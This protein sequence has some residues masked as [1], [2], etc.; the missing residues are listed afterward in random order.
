[1]LTLGNLT[2]KFAKPTDFN[3]IEDLT[4]QSVFPEP[5]EAALNRIERGFT[6]VILKHLHESPTCSSPM[7]ENVARIQHAY[8]ANPEA[9]AVVKAEIAAQSEPVLGLETMRLQVAEFLK[10]INEG[11]QDFRV[12]CVSTNIDSERLWS[13]YAENH[14]GIALR[15]EPDLRNDS[16]FQLFHPVQYRDARPSFYEDTLDFVAHSMFG[17]QEAH[18]LKATKN[19]IYT[20]TREWEYEGEYRLAIPVMPDEQPWNTLG[21]YREEITE[22]YLGMAVAPEDQKLLTRRAR[23]INPQIKVFQGTPAFGRVRFVEI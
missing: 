18:R 16:K 10:E 23:I 20:K 9:A 21:Y 7:K 19:I 11:L 14:K 3:D 1:M 8:R 17:D 12:L 4:V 6:D 22:L 2:F 5:L 15:I 13:L